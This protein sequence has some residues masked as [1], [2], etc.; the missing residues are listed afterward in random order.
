MLSA[1]SRCR[2]VSSVVTGR[3]LA[4]ALDS[5]NAAAPHH[6]C[7]SATAKAMSDAMAV[8]EQMEYDFGIVGAGPAGLCCGLRLKQLQPDKTVCV[9]EKASA[10]GAHSISGAVLEP[11]PLEQLLPQWRSDY[12]GMKIGRASCRERV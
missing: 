7:T 3:K 12:T 1:S 10:L 4:R 2:C 5:Q 9:L 6:R 8:H 11:G